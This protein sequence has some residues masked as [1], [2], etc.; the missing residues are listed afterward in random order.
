VMERVR[1][2][3]QRQPRGP[4]AAEARWATPSTC[5]GAWRATPRSVSAWPRRSH[6]AG[7]SST[8]RA[9]TS[10]SSHSVRARVRSSAHS[11]NGASCC[12]R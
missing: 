3:L 4:R 1:E 9:P 11:S 10:C 5:A 8:P 6:R 12:A 2:E 7:G